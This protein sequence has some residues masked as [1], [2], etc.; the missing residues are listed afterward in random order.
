M[1]LF[2]RFQKQDNIEAAEKVPTPTSESGQGSDIDEK[3]S[4]K[5]AHVEAKL[6]EAQVGMA[7][8]SPPPYTN[9]LEAAEKEYEAFDP[10]LGKP[11]SL[12]ELGGEEDGNQLTV[13]AVLLGS[14]LGL[15]IAASNV[16]L[17]LKT[18][19][20]FGAS[21]FGAILGF[22][23]IRALQSILPTR[24]G[25]AVS[26][27]R[28]T[29]TVQTAATA[30]GGLS[31]AFVAAIPAMY[32]LEL[33]SGSPRQD[34]GRLI[35][36]TIVSAFYGCFFAIPLRN[37]YILRLKLVFPS[38]TATAITIKGLHSIG[39]AQ[40]AKTQ[41]NV[42]LIT[43]AAAFV[44]C[45]VNQYLPGILYEWHW[46]YWLYQWGWEAAL[47]VDNWNWYFQTTP[48][49]TGAGMLAGLNA[50][51]SFLSGSILLWGII[52]PALIQTH[53]ATGKVSRS[54]VTSGVTRVS[55]NSLPFVTGETDLN[56]LTPRYWGLWVGVL[57]MF[58]AS[59]AELAM[60]GPSIYRG[61]KA[62]FQRVYAVMRHRPS[63]SADS[64][65]ET[66][67][68]LDNAPPAHQVPLWMW[69]G[70]LILSIIFTCVV[71]AVQ[72]DL[73]VG[74]SILA[75][76][77]AF[78]FSFVALHASGTTDTNP[79][80]VIAK[81]SQLIV[82]GALRG[83]PGS[84]ND[85]LLSNLIAGSIVSSA[86]QHSVDM[87]GD[88]KTGHL[89]RARP[90][91]QFYAQLLGSIPG[92]FLSPGLFVL[93]TTAYPCITDANADTCQFGLPSVLAWRAVAQAVLSPKLPVSKSSGI[94]AIL[95]AALAI[96]SVV[97]RYLWIPKKYHIWIPNFNAVGLGFV[98]P[99]TY[100]PVAMCC[101]A[102]FSHFWQKRNPKQ[103]D[104][105]GYA[106]A[107]GFIA[108]EGIAGVVNAILTIAE[109]SGDLKGNP[110]GYP[111]W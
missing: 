111:P 37:F 1:T 96:F 2:N 44:W 7:E 103:Y 6:G 100:I 42:L 48:A 68:L 70:G 19:F 82:G 20:T 89:V 21:L 9:D 5:D 15:L 35:T 11:F 16:Y 24:W 77:L 3:A 56:S 46:G 67:E 87:V 10:F 73:N 93:F 75:I 45:I 32:Q 92:I 52:G 88:L 85:H 18:G 23:G 95:F 65:E 106:V 76:V 50:S 58:A 78:L 79:L 14:V 33:L 61:F 74:I 105:A 51:F 13:R 22:A 107:A 97:A 104:V 62:A 59:A 90:R 39:G 102:L 40:R 63:P 94:T 47:V 27:P 60:N 98:L 49:F 110:V 84:M 54:A 55:Y 26:G 108:G 12:E 30:A 17:G 25:G 57:M 53:Q 71:A 99:Q 81:G 31:G 36:F 43:F 101:G 109:V 38:P 69:V 80:S 8:M 4:A 41:T 64:T 28:E 72:F 29:C 86:G 34:F 83:T 66:D 91:T